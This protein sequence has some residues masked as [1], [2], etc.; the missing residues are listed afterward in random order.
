MSISSPHHTAKGPANVLGHT[1]ILR[2]VGGRKLLGDARFQ[3]ILLERF[4][5]VFPLFVGTPA[6]DS[7]TT[8]D[9]S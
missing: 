2:C 1:I 9:N 7:A 6:N 5:R 3:A 8:R 4:A